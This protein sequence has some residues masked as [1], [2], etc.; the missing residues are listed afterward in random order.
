MIFP[1]PFFFSLPV[2]HNTLF[3][4]HA[5][6]ILNLPADVFWPLITLEWCGASA[7]SSMEMDWECALAGVCYPDWFSEGDLS[8]AFFCLIFYCFFE[9]PGLSAF[10]LFFRFFGHEQG[11]F[12]FLYDRFSSVCGLRCPGGLIEIKIYHLSRQR[13]SIIVLCHVREANQSSMTRLK[14]GIQAM[15]FRFSQFHLV[16]SL[17]IDVCNV[18]H[19]QRQDSKTYRLVFTGKF[20]NTSC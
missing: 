9:P 19:E 15:Y 14:L 8:S 3:F 5:L 4:N 12:S 20:L 11:M 13:M 16:H 17:P 18:G 6:S 1:F 7:L 10:W 2:F